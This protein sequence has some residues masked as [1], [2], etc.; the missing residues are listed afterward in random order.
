MLRQMTPAIVPR[1]EWR[2]FGDRFGAAEDRFA[3][4]EANVVQESEELYFLSVGG[5]DTAKVRG[6]LMDVKHLEQV[7][8]HGLEQWLPVLKI[9]FP[10]AADAVRS[11][12][13]GL[14]CVVPALERAEYTMA[15][16]LD[17]VVDPNPALRA[18]DVHKRRTRATI[19]GC[20]GELTEVRADGA[21]TRTIAVEHEDPERV[22]AAVRELGL[23]SR[24]NTSYPRGL[25]T[26][27]GFG[28]GRYAVLD[29]GTNSVN[30]HIAE[31]SADGAWRTVADRAEV[32]RL[33]EGLSEGGHLT[34]EAIGRTVD[35]IAATVDEAR[36]AGVLAI[37]AVGT[38]GLRIA[39]NSAEFVE[40]V[41][42]RCGITVEVIPGEEEARLAYLAATASLGLDRGSLVVFDTGGGSSQFTF[43]RGSSVEE[44]FSVNVGAARITERFGLDRAVSEDVL[45]TVL[46]AIDSDLER[47]DG[48]PTPDALIGM[49]GAV[50]NLA[51]V[52]HGLATYD[53]DIVQGTVL[54]RAEIDR[55]IELYRERDA[56]ERREI[57]GL[58]PNRAE[59]ILAGCCIVRSVLAMLDAES[60]KVS[61]RGLRHGVLVERFS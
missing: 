61:D 56:D 12:L 20:S 18:V 53:P 21:S 41:R 49:G 15:Q 24:P 27:V 9:G 4:E 45:A 46:Q 8:E 3:A 26:L 25:K 13:T 14:R 43:G 33:G 57:V 30:L 54:D 29:I 32:T 39:S 5:G 16:L 23:D 50:T 11:V 10:V 22:I 28:A 51:A 35:A 58:Q 2:T 38:A 17:E 1:W 47:L 55:Q 48:R 7:D 60:L 44:R 36:D 19:G 34:P 37:A 40:A 42:D 59:V 6:G 31:R 52:S